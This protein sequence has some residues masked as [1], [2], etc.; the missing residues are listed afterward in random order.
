MYRARDLVRAPGLLSL[1]R[2]LFA[3]AFPFAVGHPAAAT[4]ILVA[5]GLSDVLDG[6]VARR[7]GQ[8]TA[9]GT[10]IDPLTDKIFVTTVAVSLVL[11]R[12]LS[13]VDVVWL[14]T[15]ELGELPLVA[16]LAIDRGA[17]RRRAEHPSANAFGK[18]ATAAQFGT[19]AA[20]LFRVAHV[21]WLVGLT[22]IL[23]ATAALNYWA[24]EMRQ[25]RA[26]VN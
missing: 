3:A 6:W 18:L 20:A 16:W 7:S 17:R 26:A 1:S 15:R 22:A 2:L 10:A 4:A 14:S 9:T 11:A 5:A 8:V 13:A 24:R 23:G 19:A 12:F 21:E 25:R